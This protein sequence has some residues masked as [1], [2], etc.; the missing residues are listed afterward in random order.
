MKNFNKQ[1]L[2]KYFTTNNKSGWKTK[3]KHIIK[4]FDG[5]LMEINNFILNSEYDINLPFT[6]KLYNFLYDIKKIMRCDNC[7][8]IIQWKNRFSE[9][10]RN[11]CSNYCKYNSE[12]RLKKMYNTN[13]N[14]YGVKYLLQ[15]DNLINKKWN[16]INDKIINKFKINGY[17]VMNSSKKNLTIKH[18]DGH[19]FTGNRKILINRLNGGFEISTILNPIYSNYSSYEKEIKEILNIKFIEND[20]K[21]LKGKEIDIYI[22]E[23]KLG[24]E[25]NGLYW[26]SNIFVNDNYHLNK[27]ELAEEQGIQLLHIFEDEWIYKKEIVKSIIKSKIGIFDQRIYARKCEIREINDN[28]LI[29]EFLN[30]NHI[31][32]FVGSK[33]KIGLFYDNELVSLMTFGKPRRALGNKNSNDNEYELL[34]FCN[35]LNTQVLGGASKLF[36]YFISNFNPKEILSY[37]DRRYSNGSLYEKLGFNFISKTSPNY[38][39]FTKTSL[40][41]NHRFKFRK[42]VLIKEGYDPQKSE[43]QIMGERGLLRIYDCGNLKYVFFQL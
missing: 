16:T 39:Y 38:W 40:I 19:I 20:R 7:G 5:L 26:H 18:Y 15:N 10:Y 28:N 8:N 9:G 29:R 32:G 41:R 3:E 34:R 36:K 27:T 13:Q 1:Q 23:H 21:I 4:N 37:A 17:E 22:P 6:Q 31:Q 35:K 2:I 42:D 12:K 11:N 33:H 43:C 14:K 24:I 30:N 25:F